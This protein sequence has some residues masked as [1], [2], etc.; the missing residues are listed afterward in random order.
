MV[1]TELEKKIYPNLIFL[2]LACELLLEVA[3]HHNLQNLGADLRNRILELMHEMPA[4]TDDFHQTMLDL[5][6]YGDE[7]RQASIALAVLD[8]HRGD[9][10]RNAGERS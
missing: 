8:K 6:K 5:M 7:W 4:D 1:A 9:L 3:E 2:D 10:G